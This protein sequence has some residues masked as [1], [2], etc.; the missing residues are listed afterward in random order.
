MHGVLRNPLSHLTL[1]A[2]LATT[3]PSMAADLEAL[4]ARG[5][6]RK[7]DLGP[8]VRRLHGGAIRHRL[9]IDH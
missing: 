4:P 6:Q 3:I 2:A 7:L 9:V 8:L 1:V 5:Y